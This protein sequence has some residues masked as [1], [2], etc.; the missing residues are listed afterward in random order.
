[1]SWALEGDP[2]ISYKGD[3]GG[4][5]LCLGIFCRLSWTCAPFSWHLFALSVAFVWLR[6]V[7]VC[8]FCAGVS[9]YV[10]VL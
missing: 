8:G 1:M 2:V 7:H 9:G 10:S 4:I 3:R 5:L 6:V